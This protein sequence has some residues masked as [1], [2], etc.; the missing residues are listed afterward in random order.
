MPPSSHH[1]KEA[2]SPN[3]GTFCA[4]AFP[5]SAAKVYHFWASPC[6]W[7]DIPHKKQEILLFP[8]HILLNKDGSTLGW[9]YI[10]TRIPD[11][12]WY[13]PILSTNQP[14]VDLVHV[15][16][17]FLLNAPIDFG[18]DSPKNAENV[19]DPPRFCLLT[20]STSSHKYHKSPRISPLQHLVPICKP[21][22]WDL[23][24]CHH[25]SLTSWHRVFFR[26]WSACEGL[27]R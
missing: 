17:L 27:Y 8:A 16:P 12:H 18:P 7:K 2:N 1:K 23:V 10:M 25:T 21:S 9:W 22:F 14:L 19:L 20:T 24:Q 26:E 11:C 6:N 3:P 4:W 13:L 5:F 15:H